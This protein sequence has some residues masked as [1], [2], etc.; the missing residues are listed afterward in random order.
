MK[1]LR[2][3]TELFHAGDRR[4]ERQIDRHDEVNNRF[5]T[6]TDAATNGYVNQT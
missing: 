2:V 1:I 4:A 6:F 3:G 5:S